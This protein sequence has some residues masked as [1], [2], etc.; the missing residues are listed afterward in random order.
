MPQYFFIL[1]KNPTLS[2]AEIISV[3]NKLQISFVI[4]TLSTE[5]LILSTAVELPS[6]FIKTLGGTVKI[7]KIIDEVSLDDDEQKFEKIFEGQNIADNYLSTR[8]GKLHFGISIYDG[9]AEEKYIG[10]ISNQLKDLCVTVKQ[11]LQNIGLKAGFVRIKERYL[12]SVSVWKN[13]LLGKGMEIVLILTNDKILA[14]KTL[15]VQE[16]ESFSFRD[17]GR[18]ERDT[19]SGLIPPKLARMMINLASIPATSVLFDPFCGSGTILQEAVILGYQN[20]IGTDI[21]GSATLN[22]K[23]NIDWLFLN[24]KQL[25][26]SLYNINVYQSDVRSINSSI[27][28]NSIDA[29]VTEPYLGPPL[30]KKPDFDT[31]K[32]ILLEV[33]NLNL[34]AFTEFK[35]ILKIGGKV[36]I[37]FPV[38]EDKGISYY[39]EILD[40]IKSL[41]FKHKDFFAPGLK[42][43]PFLRLTPRKTIL[44]GNKEQFVLREV[45]SFERIY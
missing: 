22:T 24:F 9:G 5:V 29:I 41:G 31:I 32:K 20:I 6:E 30:F 25:D 15:V 7:G 45:F 17:Y 13:Q 33:S 23:K 2:T 18:P 36:I 44:Y 28:S 19:K 37:I 4:K 16:F 12:T 1:G 40:K 8:E 3:L 27:K 35:K 38:F 39:L 14:G 42:E 43:V 26:S 10:K 21:S 11:N 34:T